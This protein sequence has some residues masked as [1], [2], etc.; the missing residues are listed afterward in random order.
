[1]KDLYMN[2]IYFRRYTDFIRENI[3]YRIANIDHCR[4]DDPRKWWNMIRNVIP[5][6]AKIISGNIFLE[7]L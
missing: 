2:K 3:K 5:M 7:K 6:K 1:M 4:T